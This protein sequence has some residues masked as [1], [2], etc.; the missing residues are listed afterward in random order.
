MQN[1]KHQ[2]HCVPH[3]TKNQLLACLGQDELNRLR[4][5]L[6]PVSW[7]ADRILLERM[8]TIRQIWFPVTCIASLSVAVEQGIACEAAIIGADGI[9]GYE[10]FLGSEVALSRQVVQIPGLAYQLPIKTARA[11]F[12]DS[13]LFHR[14]VM[15]YVA[16]LHAEILQSVACHGLHAGRRRM[17]R[18]LLQIQDCAH[19]DPIVNL[20]H[21]ML[22]NVLGVQRTTI[23]AAA[24]ELQQEG[25]I[26][27][28]RGRIE[29]LHRDRLELAACECYGAI[30]ANFERLLPQRN[31]FAAAREALAH[32]AP[33]RRM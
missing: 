14:G 5:E 30:R 22:A 29:L 24:M 33:M 10:A 31:G 18:L 15:G 23:T 17:A 4:Q 16:A 26:T 7:Q 6:V 27:Y 11:I 3:P 21:E 13:P 19:G 1:G 32:P 20:T 28:R 2:L 9:I 25:L 8:D 12:E